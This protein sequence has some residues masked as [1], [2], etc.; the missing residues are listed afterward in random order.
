[1]K[2]KAVIGVLW[3][4]AQNSHQNM[5]ETRDNSPLEAL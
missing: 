1:M 2:T 4:H 5:E 3:L